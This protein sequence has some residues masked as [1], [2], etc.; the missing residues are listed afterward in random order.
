MLIAIASVAVPAA[1][2]QPLP[3]MTVVVL[4]PEAHG[5][6]LQNHDYLVRRTWEL[7]ATMNDQG[8][9]VIRFADTDPKNFAACLVK[10]KTDREEN[11][12]QMDNC[13]R[14][15]LPAQS[16]AVPVAVVIRHMRWRSAAQQMTCIAAG[17]PDVGRSK[18]H[19]GD[20]FHRYV[21]L[22]ATARFYAREC[23]ARALG[24]SDAASK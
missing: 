8:I 20:I 3:E 21:D 7:L 6:H 4:S 11:E 22:R 9:A 2:A 14:A 16:G 5:P 18:I 17:R 24:H 23:L 10:S 19:P 15:A 12:G 1:P 13:I